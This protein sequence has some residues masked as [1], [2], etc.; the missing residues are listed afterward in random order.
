VNT[1]FTGEVKDQSQLYGLLDRLCDLGLE[2]I[3]V[4]PQTEASRAT[5]EDQAAR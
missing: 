1:A 5:G 3:S 4:Q 2:P